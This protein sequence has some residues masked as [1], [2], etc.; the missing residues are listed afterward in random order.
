MCH[1]VVGRKG[2]DW[3]MLDQPDSEERAR[4]F[5]LPRGIVCRCCPTAQ[6]TTPVALENCRCIHSEVILWALSQR[7]GSIHQRFDT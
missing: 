7:F 4:R 6:M 1:T 3:A 2:L 5:P